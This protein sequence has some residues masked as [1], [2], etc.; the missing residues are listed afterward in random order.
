MAVFTLIGASIFGAGTF[1]AGVTA[2][3]LKTAAGIGLNLLAQ[4][5][6]GKPKAPTFSIQ[7]DIRAG[8]DVPRSIILGRYMTAGSRVW[9]NTWGNANKTPNAYF[10]DV[11]ALSDMPSASLDEVWADNQ[12]LT[13]LTGS[14][15]AEMGIPV[16][17]YRKD[18]RDH[19]WVKFYDGTQTTA[20]SFL[21]S[22]VGSVAFPYESTRV[23]YGIT[24]A[25]VTCLINQELF[26]DVPQFRF[27]VQGMKLYD[28]SKDTTAGGSGSQRWN[29]PSTWG[30]DGDNL[31]AVQIYNLCRGIRYGSVWQHGLQTISS[32]RVPVAEWIPQINKCRASVNI[33]GGGTELMYRSGMELQYSGPI[34]NAIEELLTACQ[35]RMPFDGVNYTMR[36]GEPDA[37][38][39][40]IT[41]DVIITTEKQS[42]NPFRQLS[43]TINGVAATFPNP[44]AA[45]EVTELPLLFRTDLEVLDGDRRLLTDFTF[46]TV[47]S[48][49]Q[50]QRLMD[51]A[52]KEARRERRHTFTLPPN[53]YGL[54]PG[55]VIDYSSVRNG[56]IAKLF[57]VESKSR[58]PNLDILID[59][60]EIDPTD[61]SYNTGDYRSVPA[62]QVGL[63]RPPAQPIVDWSA[64]AY[65]LASSTTGRRRPAILL[66]WDGDVEDVDAVLFE[67][68]LASTSE[69][70]HV[71]TTNDVERGSIIIT[72]SLLP[73][74]AYQ[75][76]GR[77]WSISG[78]EFTWSSWLNVTTLEEVI[79]GDQIAP[80]SIT[81][82]KFG[83]DA[84]TIWDTQLPSILGAAKEFLSRESLSRTLTAQL[85]TARAQFTEQIDVIATDQNALAQL[86]QQLTAELNSVSASA[87][88][89]MV[90][91]AG[92][93]GAAARIEAQVRIDTGAT[94]VRAGWALDVLESPPGSGTYTSRFLIYADNILVQ[95]S[96]GTDVLYFNAVTGSLTLFGG[97]LIA[98]YIG[99]QNGRWQQDM[100]NAVLKI[101]DESNVR[102]VQLG[103]LSA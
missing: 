97:T 7:T 35:G 73:V 15:H 34:A 9:F 59:L 5:I 54:R 83:M 32:A 80:H 62:V 46:N 20:D 51:S 82:P 96:S 4:A 6:A 13:L 76:R 57:R 30:G 48:Q 68:R 88:F 94:W 95:N 45:W 78:R 39:A 42:F 64:T 38:V 63:A 17:E 50:C 65:D 49:Y 22:K 25:I 55:H 84:A 87:K 79:T 71:G 43:D 47:T 52:L 92:P 75:A 81:V 40:S 69:V 53:F 102:R 61:Y 14:P 8:G 21:T 66:E 86:V 1:L 19:M 98:G 37:S 33:P 44:Q 70:V 90:A 72:Q 89:R 56:Y 101:F 67:V 28:P 2:F 24:Y 29:N 36:L 3:V 103:D 74:T 93:G 18:G 26:S 10:T 60:I 16:Q 77:Y 100:T 11:I 58:Q 12:K 23:G 85:G 99:D 41:D 31:P 27:V 91:V